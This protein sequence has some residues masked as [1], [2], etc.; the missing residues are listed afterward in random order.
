MRIAGLDQRVWPGRESGVCPPG[1]DAAAAD[2][3][4]LQR[5][6]QQPGRDEDERIQRAEPEAGQF[7]H[8]R[9]EKQDGGDDGEHGGLLSRSGGVARQATPC[10]YG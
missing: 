7:E 8:Q 5:E 9:D 1:L 10:G 6:A 4:E 3:D 2:P